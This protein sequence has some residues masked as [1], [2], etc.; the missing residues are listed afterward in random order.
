[1]FI[2]TVKYLV[3]FR[4]PKNCILSDRAN[5]TVVLRPLRVLYGAVHCRTMMDSHVWGA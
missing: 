1:M 3:M 2:R 5:T 4:I